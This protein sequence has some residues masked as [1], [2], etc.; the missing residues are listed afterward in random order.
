MSIGKIPKLPA[1]GG[2]PKIGQ[3]GE[4]GKIPRIP[5]GR[6]ARPQGVGQFETRA[7]ALEKRAKQGVMGS[8]PERLIWSWLDRTGLLF[9]VQESIWGGKR[10]QGGAVLDFQIWGLAAYPVVIRVQGSFWHG[11][12]APGR[13]NN[14]DRVASR[15]MASGFIVVDA[16][17]TDIENYA[18]T[19]H[20]GQL[21]NR[22]LSM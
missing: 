20:I 21:I 1:L 3:I 17:E 7:E 14:D 16:W 13:N 6:I 5:G 8:L 22:L 10:V 12:A 15:L 18:L 9:T 4:L 11:P 2:L 19:G